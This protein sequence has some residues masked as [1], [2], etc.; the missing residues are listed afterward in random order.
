MGKGGERGFLGPPVKF[1]APVFRKLTKISDVGA[2]GPRAAGRL[3]R[4]ACA[5]KTVA[6]VGDVGVRDTKR[7]WGGFDGH[8]PARSSCRRC[9]LRTYI[10]LSASS[11]ALPASAWGPR[12]ATPVDAP[13][14]T[15]R[16]PNTKLSRSTACS[17][18]AALARASVSV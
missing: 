8:D 7:E 16:P 10:A 9:A 12:I 1:V 4:E 5:G 15:I 11:S 18:D 13:V 6:E 17:S 2:I 14:A 3:V